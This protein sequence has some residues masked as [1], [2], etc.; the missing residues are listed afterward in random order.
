MGKRVLVVDDSAMM[1]KLIIKALAEGGHE[2]LGEA[3]N[4]REA[5]SL[6]K[7]LQPDVVAMDITMRDLDGFAAAKQIL[8]FDPEAVIIFVSNLDGDKYGEQTLRL[9]AKGF[10]GKRR[11]QDFIDLL[12][13]L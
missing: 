5:V 13:S 9:G 4:G 1:R 3:K 2:A 8:E 10:V 12:E 6:Y 11:S 7:K